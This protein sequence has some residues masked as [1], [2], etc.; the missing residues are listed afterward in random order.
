[1]KPSISLRRY[2]G[3]DELGV[4]EEVLLE[5][6]LVGRQ[7]EEPV[8]LGQ[9]LERDVGVVRADRAAGRLL[10]VGAR[11]GS[12]RSG[13]TSPRTS[14][15]RCRRSRC[16]RRT[17]SWAARTWSG[18]VVRMNRSGLIP[19]ASSAALNRATFSSTKSLGAL[20]SSAARMGDV[21]RVLVGAGQEARRRR[22]SSGASGRWRRR[23]SPRTA[24][25]CRA[26]CWR[27]RSRSS[28]NSGQAWVESWIRGARARR[29]GRAGQVGRGGRRPRSRART[30]GAEP[31]GHRHRAPGSRHR[32]MMRDAAIR[33][34]SAGCRG[35]AAISSRRAAR[36]SAQDRVVERR[37]DGARGTR[38]RGPRRRP[39]RPPRG[40]RARRGCRCRA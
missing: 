31:P 30:V 7:P 14:R 10:D 26:C 40:P 21:D 13:S 3:L 28:G 17:I 23:R 6:L 12:P 11:C 32:P 24:C 29:A 5:P 20:P 37:P 2:V 27:R 35:L 8:L 9:P 36:A 34:S 16:A 1:M 18:S 4:V 19:S 25:G 22:P 38:R 15:G 39:G 33:G